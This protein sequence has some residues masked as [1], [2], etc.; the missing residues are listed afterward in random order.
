MTESPITPAD[1]LRPLEPL[2]GKWQSSGT[3][4]DDHGSPVAKVSGTDEYEWMA[5]GRWI[6]HSVDVTMGDERTLAIEMI[7]SPTP[8][9]TAFTMRAF[10]ATGA[11]DTMTLTRVPDGSLRADGDGSR[12]TL[13]IGE[14]GGSM[15]ARWE[16]RTTV[17]DWLHWMDMVFVRSQN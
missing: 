12:S 2:I 1:N 3:I 10:D 14:D 13:V 11:F 15:S 5:G 8:D 7:G 6:V 9:G 4:F 17:G 16:K